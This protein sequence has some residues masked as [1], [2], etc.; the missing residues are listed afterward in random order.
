MDGSQ[1][2]PQRVLAPLRANLAANRRIDGLCLVVAA[3]ILF[4]NGQSEAGVHYVINDPLQPRLSSACAQK[5][6]PV[7]AVLSIAEIF[8]SDLKQDARFEHGVR[9]AYARLRI[10]GVLASVELACQHAG[11]AN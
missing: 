10:S 1:K 5:Q 7:G 4:L 8:G 11:K 9:Q 3:W 6:D 2:L